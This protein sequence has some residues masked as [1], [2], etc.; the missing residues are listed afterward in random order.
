MQ[1][2]HGYIEVFVGSDTLWSTKGWSSGFLS[3]SHQFSLLNPGTNFSPCPPPQKTNK[4][5]KKNP[6]KNWMMSRNWKDKEKRRGMI[7]LGDNK[8]V[9]REELVWYKKPKVLQYGW[10]WRRHVIDSWDHESGTASWTKTRNW[11]SS[12]EWSRA[13]DAFNQKSV[14]ISRYAF[15]KISLE[16]I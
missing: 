7:S 4:Q 14:I 16:D 5:T 6:K 10:K 15:K 12:W 8:T 13:L 2:S 1:R 11:S 9:T 3:M